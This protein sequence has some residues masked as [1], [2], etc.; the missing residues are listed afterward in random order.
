MTPEL[1]IQTATLLAWM[2]DAALPFW[3]EVQEQSGAWPEDLFPDGTPHTRAVRRHRVQAR[4]LFT[5]ALATDRGWYDGKAIVARSLAY[6]WEA[7]L[8]PDPEA[9][10]LI[11]R[12]NA[13]GTVASARQDLYDHA[14]YALGTAWAGHVLGQDAIRP[15]MN[16]LDRFFDDLRHPRGG[17]REGIPED[18][19]R[20][21]N[22]HMHLFEMMLHLHELNQHFTLSGLRGLT[23]E[24]LYALFETR[25]FDPAR[26]MVRE[27]FDP[28]W[29]PRDTP[30]EPGHAVEW[31][32]L[33]GWWE[34]QSGTS[35]RHYRDALYAS[36]L[37][38]GA[39]WLFDEVEP[40]E[41]GWQPARETSRLWVQTELAKAHLTQAEHGERGAA[42]MAA[43]AIEGLL[44]DWLEPR[45]TWIDKRGACGQVLSETIPTSTF[46]HIA[47]LVA[48]AERVSRL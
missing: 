44:K 36:A 25:F 30:F 29:T 24:S 5:Y 26:G 18:P 45:G 37:G 11:H 46:Y 47:G 6:I 41:H 3:A 1:R 23:R 9:K 16:R 35:T 22:P 21:Q 32:W 31:V 10:G 2:R 40:G 39:I 15:A 14:F 19:F 28:D 8:H 4:Q 34:R 38:S 43:L 12:V 33:L 7:G 20:R 27:Y 17:F 42:D 13:D 48:E